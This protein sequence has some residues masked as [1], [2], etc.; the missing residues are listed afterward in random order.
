M[1]RTAAL[2]A[3]CIMLLTT[4]SCKVEFYRDNVHESDY[5]SITQEEARNIMD[6]ESDIVIVDVRRKEEYDAGHIHGAILIPNET[7][8]DTQP[9]ELPDKGQKILIYCRSGS[10]SQQAAR[11]LA[12][13]GYTNIYEFGG[14]D[15][16]QYGLEA[17]ETVTEPEIQPE[18]EPAV[19]SLI[20]S[21]EELGMYDI[22]GEGWN[23]A[24]Y[25]DGETYSAEYEYDNWHITNSYRIKNHNDLVII[26]Q[27]LA[28]IHPIH[29]ADMENFRS[30]EDM[31][32]EWEQHNLAYNLLPDD[33]P[34]KSSAKDVDIDPKDQG[35]S[36]Y[37]LF[38]DRVQ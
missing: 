25:Y 24:F 15:T 7:I 28:D 8:S 18:T 34:W 32:Y 22:D 29:S 38:M 4:A 31:A 17:A 3:C 2:L 6:S 13:M 12:K 9:A 20:S 14:A 1:K 37:Q 10:C 33:S 26:C 19:P 35:K 30:A 16:W 21:A 5:T 27:A 11:K 36:A 23:Y